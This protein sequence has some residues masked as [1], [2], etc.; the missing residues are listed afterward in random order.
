MSRNRIN[1]VLCALTV[2][3]G[4]A[5]IFQAGTTNIQGKESKV[6][7][8]AAEKEFLS[9]I[10]PL[11][12]HNETDWAPF[13]LNENGVPK[14]FSIDYMNLVAQKVGVPIKYISGPSWNDFLEMMKKG[15]LDVML[16]IAKSP[17]RQQFLEF[18]RAYV[19]MVQMLYTRKDYPMVSSI[20]D[21]YGKRFAIPKGFYLH[22]V[23]KAHPKIEIMEVANTSAAIR[24]VSVGQADA[25]FDL[26]P[27]VDYITKQLQITN[28]KVGGDVGLEEGKPIPL[29]M[30]TRK[31]LRVLAAVLEKGIAAITDEELQKLHEKWMTAGLKDK[32]A[33]VPASNVNLDLT[34]EEKTFIAGK[35]L[36][37]GLD[38]ARPPF[39][40]IDEKGAY[41]GISAEFMRAAA[42]KLGVEVVPL[43]DM[44]WT[45]AMEKVKVG[46]V[47]VIPKVTPSKEREKF[48][49]FT[50][51]YTTFPSVI[52]TRK[53]RLAGGMDDLRG[54]K[55][56]V[57]K[58]QIIE[59]NLKRDRPE[60]TLVPSP[61]IETALRELSG[62]K[63]DAFIDNLGAVSYVMDK[64]GLTNLR[65]A[66]STPYTHDLAFGI[67]KDWPLMASALDKALASMSDQEKTEI[68][69]RWLAIQFQTGIPWHIVGPIGATLLAI[70]TFVVLWNRRLGRAVRERQRAEQELRQQAEVLK[71]QQEKLRETE[72]WYRGIIE[73]APD[74]IIV[75]DD[76]GNI[77]LSNTMADKMFGYESG[78]LLGRNV[79]TLVPLTRR[80]GHDHRRQNF[81]EAGAVREMGPGLD[82]MGVRKDDS[83]YPV[84]IGLSKLPALGSRGPCVCASIRDITQ[85]KAAEKALTEAEERSRLLLES[86]GEGIFGIDSSGK[87]TFAN[88]AALRMLGY[89]EE[90][91]LG[92]KIHPI[93]HHSRPDGSP[94]P[95]EECPSAI[96]YRQGT[97]YMST[98]DMLWRKDGTG[99]YVDYA[100]TPIVKEGQ[101]VGAVATFQDVSERRKAE[102]EMRRHVRE[103]ERFNRLVTGREKKMIQLKDEINTLREEAGK[104]AKYMVAVQARQDREFK[105]FSEERKESI[106]DWNIVGN[107]GEGRPNLGTTIDV[108]VYR[109]MHLALRDVIVTRFNPETAAM[110]FYEAGEHMGRE[111][112]QAMMEKHEN[113]DEFIKDTQELL[114]NLKIGLLGI[115]KIDQEKMNFILTISEDLECSG[116]SVSN[117]TICSYDEGFLSGLLSEHTGR[118]FE[119]KEVDC[120]CSGDKLCRFEVR[121]S[122]QA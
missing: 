8:T 72:A 38:Q 65:I 24:A 58:G 3:I 99:F 49:I 120:W 108:G 1:P 105:L 76:Q 93:I 86:V 26:M 75:A 98:N 33:T 6:D 77:I 68:K 34:A 45:V 67:R 101:V 15:E 106:F 102:E 85:R 23:L 107:I 40:Y 53:D 121:P 31:D 47:D 100:A 104:S 21:L 73:S 69:N 13:N 57:I 74:G 22:E 50:K 27:V 43:K 42:K 81:M 54:S 109:L 115:E 70:I 89:R 9:K 41:E 64:V 16:N 91:L 94:Y 111:L 30:A 44:K 59:V 52:V 66:A 110:I 17:E 62:G 25:L 56:G 96:S 82:L 12:V 39:E 71:E 80:D 63:T 83:E 37:L 95:G 103:L 2:L 119:V 29:H 28:L 114:A 48:L 79:D 116:M 113:L 90:E 32:P 92:Q 19:T 112:Y 118:P 51:P 36:R 35:E 87:M 10:G 55:V 117:E 11:R 88:P 78:E 14:G 122:N 61:D 20:K 5:L 18:T 7:L 97:A 60:L 84:D 46:E 4:A